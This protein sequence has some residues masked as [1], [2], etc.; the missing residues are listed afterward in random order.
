MAAVLQSDHF[1]ETQWAL[2]M[3]TMT[4]CLCFSSNGIKSVIV[5]VKA[6]DGHDETRLIQLIV[7]VFLFSP[8]LRE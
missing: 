6:N 5:L 8:R 3:E 2:M 4:L 7:A 1:S